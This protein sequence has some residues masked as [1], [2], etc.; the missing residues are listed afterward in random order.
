MTEA[1]SK[2]A[3]FLR[4]Y[5]TV[6]LVKP[7][8]TDENVDKVKEKFRGIVGREGGKFLRF[9]IWGK[10]KTQYL[11]AKQPRAIYLHAHYLGKPSLVAE[12]ERNLR[13]LDEVS[14]YMSKRL[15]D[16]IDPTTREAQE[17]LKLAG[18][19]DDNKP[20]GGAEREDFNADVDGSYDDD[21]T[22][23]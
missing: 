21:I 7:D 18:D 6:F 14:R 1:A 23:G 3:S 9:T 13:N 16:D 10:K 12:V 15:A 5:E 11:V 17:D 2:S 19:V 22:P 8:L 4:E 20:F